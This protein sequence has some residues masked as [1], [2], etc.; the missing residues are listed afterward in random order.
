MGEKSTMGSGKMGQSTLKGFFTAKPGS[1]TVSRPLVESKRAV[2]VDASSGLSSPDPPTM[3]SSAKSAR[4]GH[5][6]NVPSDERPAT[7]RGAPDLRR[8]S[9][10]TQLRLTHLPLLHSCKECHMSYVRGG[11]DE[12]VHTKHHGRV[13]RGIPWEGLGRGSSRAGA[14]AKGRALSRNGSDGATTAGSGSSGPGW[15]EVDEFGAGGSRWE[16][17]LG[18]VRIVEC[19]AGYGGAKVRPPPAL[20]RAVD[21]N[22]WTLGSDAQSI[23]LT[24]S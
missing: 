24:S 9:S 21:H 12:A 7:I 6:A 18:R 2:N 19:D 22:C 3:P 8:P 14:T 15:K 11:E 23:Q 20:S 4:S 16:G 13:V 17:R 5:Q 10:H 1:R